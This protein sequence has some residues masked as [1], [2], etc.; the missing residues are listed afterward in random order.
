M[1]MRNGAL[2]IE[3]GFHQEIGWERQTDTSA[4]AVM[5]FSDRIDN[6][7]L[8]AMGHFTRSGLQ[9][10]GVLFDP[11]CDLMRVAGPAFSSDRAYRPAC[12][13]GWLATTMCA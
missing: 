13:T 2:T 7:V 4:L 6:P 10:S 1:A 9:A 12:S 11:G 5:V 3:H 8:E